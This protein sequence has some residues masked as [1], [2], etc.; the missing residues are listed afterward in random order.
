MTLTRTNRRILSL[1]LAGAIAALAIAGAG[2]SVTAT[3][4]Q[5]V[6]QSAKGA[7]AALAKGQVEKAVQLAEA[8]VA[9]NPREPSYR[10]LLGQAYL[11]AGRFNSAVTTFNDAMKLGDNSARTA[12]GLALANVAAGQPR[13]AVAILDDWRDAI[14]AADLGLALA[15]AGETSRGVAVLSDT[16][17]AGDAS[18]KVRQNLAYAYALDGR[19][20]DA[21]VM[22]AM[23]VPADQIDARMSAW[24]QHAKPEDVNVRV[25]GLINAPLRGDPGQPVAL[26]LNQS[27]ASEQLAAEQGA[28]PA[29][30]GELAPAAAS[31]A[32]ASYAPV[33]PAPAAAAEAAPARNFAQSFSSQEVVQPLPA[34]YTSASVV[35]SAKAYAKPY[36]VQARIASRAPAA[37]AVPAANGSHAVQ[38]GSF[39]SPQGARRAWGIL[40]ARNPGLQGFKMVIT[41]ATVRGKNY[42]RVAAAGFDGRSANGM[43][44]SVKSRGGV[45][46][47]YMAKRGVPAGTAAA[48]AMASAG[49]KAPAGP[50]LARRR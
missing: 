49:V 33:V 8:L 27:P 36:K 48:P 19:W 47:A 15:L 13:D 25:A 50:G 24:A 42:W 4:R 17:R 39:S 40:A 7:Q 28:A 34:G 43:C 23:D 14:P 26:A 45:C 16:L 20:R 41:P 9:A 10:A 35:A 29:P 6:D 38:L 37:K 30:K 2:M 11:K 5:S 46:F 12:L 1:G 44:A 18:P 31:T 22:M 3:A 32:L 21:R